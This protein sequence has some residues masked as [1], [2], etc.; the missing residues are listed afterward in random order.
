MFVPPV[1]KGVLKAEGISDVKIVADGERMYF[2]VITPRRDWVKPTCKELISYAP[3]QALHSEYLLTSNFAAGSNNDERV[4]E[5]TALCGIWYSENGVMD[6]SR[7]VL[8]QAAGQT[9]FSLLPR[10]C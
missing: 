8:E 9:I 1:G 7:N 4:P 10:G 2:W 5:L 3:G 6:L